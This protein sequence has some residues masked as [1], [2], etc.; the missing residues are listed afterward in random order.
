MVEVLTH[1]G[2]GIERAIKTPVV[3]KNLITGSEIST[4]GIW[5]T[6]ASGSV[7]T[8]KA[9]ADLGLTLVAMTEVRGVHGAEIVP[10]YDVQLTL[11]NQ[12]ISMR[13]RITV[14]IR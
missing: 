4:K 2:S 11:N 10:V 6:G 1:L 13:C 7:I 8:S 9:A 14:S 3:V 12:N 5:D